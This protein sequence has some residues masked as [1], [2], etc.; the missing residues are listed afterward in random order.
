[1]SDVAKGVRRVAGFSN[2]YIVEEPDGGLTL[3][4][5]GFQPSGDK[6]LAEVAA[7]GKKPSD[8]TTIVLTHGHQDHSR[9]AAK[10]KA[11][12]GAKLAAH[13]AEVDY[14]TQESRY[15]TA[16]GAMRVMTGLM[17]LFVRVSPVEVDVVLNG[18]EKIGRLA[19]THTPGHTPGSI[20]LVDDET[21][22][23]FSGDTVVT[24]KQGLLGPNRSF[25]MDMAEANRS[26]VKISELRFETVLP[27]HGDPF[28][29]ADAPRLVGELA[30]ASLHPLY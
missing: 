13:K 16:G 21:K 5:C 6:I 23:L 27:G 17:G 7:M 29:S 14:L 18:G 15:P 11:A 3:V 30:K 4:D 24:G 8:V 25:T 19:A 20:V 12:T 9:G 28:T 2:S 26:I 10:V 22:S 1:L